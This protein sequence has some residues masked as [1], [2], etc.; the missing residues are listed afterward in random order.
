MM[1]SGEIR[2][3]NFS[4]R[5]TSDKGDLTPEFLDLALDVL[6][7]VAD[8]VELIEGLVVPASATLP[9]PPSEAGNVVRLDPWRKRLDAIQ[10]PAPH[11]P[12]TPA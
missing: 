8:R 9:E 1:L 6:A 4:L 3:I 5:D 12:A 11:H 2:A 10:R 7:D